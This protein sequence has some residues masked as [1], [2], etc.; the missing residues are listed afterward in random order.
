M[1]G[2]NPC[3]LLICP[4]VSLRGGGCRKLLVGI[5]RRFAAIKTQEGGTSGGEEYDGARAR[6]REKRKGLSTCPSDKWFGIIPPNRT[7]GTQHPALVPV[8]HGL[9]EPSLLPSPEG[10]SRDNIVKRSS[11]F[12]FRAWC[13]LQHRSIFILS[14]PTL[15]PTCGK[16]NLDLV[17]SKIDGEKNI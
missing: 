15:S 14:S 17:R 16:P 3:T 11:L 5:L 8:S 1:S 10:D 4:R 12:S 6:E 2:K 13:E 9:E 7:R